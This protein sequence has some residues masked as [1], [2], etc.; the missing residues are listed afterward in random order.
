MKKKE[1]SKGK[2][3]I[4][5]NF[6]I[7]VLMS[8]DVNNISERCNFILQYSCYEYSKRPE[9][10]SLNIAKRIAAAGKYYN[11]PF[12][13]DDYEQGYALYHEFNNSN[14]G[15]NKHPKCGISVDMILA[16]RDNP[17]NE[18]EVESFLGFCAIRS[19]LQKQPYFKLTKNYLVARMAGMSTMS[20]HT[21]ANENTT[22]YQN[23]YHFDKLIKELSDHWGLKTYAK[24]THGVYV[25]FTMSRFE[26]GKIAEERKK[27]NKVIREAIS[28]KEEDERIKQSVFY[29]F[30]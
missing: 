22:K 11:I 29:S 17:K 9:L 20:E 2:K 30:I 6:P 1:E 26:I 18:F 28:R 12:S 5:I 7:K 14:S 24:Y 23:R 15:L 13:E 21:K 3:P 16:F 10:T 27:K 19:I 25:S 4:Y 8:S